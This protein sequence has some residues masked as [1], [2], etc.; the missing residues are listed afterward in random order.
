[1]IAEYATIIQRNAL[2][3]RTVWPELRA[4]YDDLE[5]AGIA[6]L[7]AALEWGAFAP[8]DHVYPHASDLILCN[9]L[10]CHRSWAARD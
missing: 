7:C 5:V 6:L 8:G 1:V 3:P 10:C 2:R 9:A 4:E